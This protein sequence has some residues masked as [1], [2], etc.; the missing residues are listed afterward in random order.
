[1]YLSLSVGGEKVSKHTKLQVTFSSKISTASKEMLRWQKRQDG[2]G[3]LVFIQL[4]FQCLQTGYLQAKLTS[5]VTVLHLKNRWLSSNTVLPYFY[6]F[7][8]ILKSCFFLQV[9][10]EQRAY[11]LW[12]RAIKGNPTLN[13]FKRRGSEV[14]FR[15]A[16]K[17]IL[18]L[19]RLTWLYRR[20]SETKNNPPSSL[21]S[22]THRPLLLK[23]SFLESYK[24]LPTP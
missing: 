24:W 16:Q 9:A 3:C 5:L 15:L 2:T 4:C 23:H 19:S 8:V 13:P 21:Y 17:D 6:E 10:R 7:T 1:M 12:W 22:N 20:Y 18:V 14:L 11:S